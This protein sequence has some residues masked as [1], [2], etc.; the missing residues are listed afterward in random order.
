[1]R[2]LE[3]IR[4]ELRAMLP[5]LQQ[6]WPL[7]A[8]GVFGSYARQSARDDSDLDLLV[9]F[10]EPIAFSEILALEDE[11]GSRLGLKVETVTRAALRPRIGRRILDELQ[12][13]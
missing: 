12:P 2:S 10:E 13:V 6:R 4:T 3:E 7:S 8:I 11:I 9:D 1:L 5:E